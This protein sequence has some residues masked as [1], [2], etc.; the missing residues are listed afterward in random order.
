MLIGKAA[1]SRILAGYI[2]A[3][4]FSENDESD[5]TGGQPFD[6]NYDESDIH[7]ETRIAMRNDCRSFYADNGLLIGL[8]G[9]ALED[10]G[11]NFWFD[12]QGHGVGFEDRADE[13]DD[14]TKK[15]ARRELSEAAREW[16][17]YHLWV[18]D[19]VD[20]GDDGRIHGETE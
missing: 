8:S 11:I 18:G 5:E 6:R 3:A 20:H 9:M 17:P 13:T 19:H 14:D 10:V 1:V 16:R 2:C 7:P 4:L 12:R 15:H